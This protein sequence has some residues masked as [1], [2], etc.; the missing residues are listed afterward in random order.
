MPRPPPMLK[1][2]ISKPRSMSSSTSPAL[3]ST[4]S[5]NG[6]S[7]VI[8]DPICW[9]TPIRSTLLYFPTLSASASAS[10]AGMPNLSN[11]RPAPP[12]L[13]N[14]ALEKGG[15]YPLL[16]LDERRREVEARGIELYDFGTGDPREPTDPKIR[17]ALVEGV[18]EG[19]QYPAAQG[20]KELRE[21]FCG[22]I[23]RRHGVELDP[24]AE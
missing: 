16:R 18:P 21:A 9:W 11:A 23:S 4:D 7:L 24:D 22:W 14:P 3:F 8:W 19:S 17:R 1:Y 2:L 20:K 6:A 12:P 13:L 10:S 5:A 15:A